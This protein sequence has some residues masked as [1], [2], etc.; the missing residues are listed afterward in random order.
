L[1]F[2]SK[3]SVED[4]HRQTISNPEFWPHI[5]EVAQFTTEPKNEVRVRKSREMSLKNY[6]HREVVQNKQMNG[7]PNIDIKILKNF[8]PINFQKVRKKSPTNRLR[9]SP[10]LNERDVNESPK[11]KKHLKPTLFVVEQENKF[12]DDFLRV[13]YQAP[14]KIPASRRDIV[15]NHRRSASKTKLETSVD[16]MLSELDHQEIDLNNKNTRPTQRG[17]ISILKK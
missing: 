2:Y 5:I 9:Q 4:F 17:V 1:L 8:M 13:E 3:T 11:I 14:S 10:S 6:L 16:K 15:I 7:S 12:I